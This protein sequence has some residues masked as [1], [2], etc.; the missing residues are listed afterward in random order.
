MAQSIIARLLGGFAYYALALWTYVFLF[1][2]SLRNGAFFTAP[3]EKDKNHL[4]IGTSENCEKESTDTDTARDQFWNLHKSPI[5]GFSH[6]FHV[7]R[8]GQQLHYICNQERKSQPGNLVILIHGFPDSCLMWKSLLSEPAIP[9]REATYVCVDLPGYGGSDSLGVH[10]TAVLEALTEFVVAMR[11]TFLTTDGNGSASK[12][13]YIVAHDWGGVLSF[14][15]AAEAPTLA[16]RFIIMN[17]PLVE[18]TLANGERIKQSSEK[19]FKQFRQSP[20]TN[21]GC[22]SKA[23]KTAAPLFTQ[24]LMSGYVA[25]FQLPASMVK[26]LGSGGN[27]AFTRGVNSMEHRGSNP[28]HFQSEPLAT[29]LGPSVNECEPS[30]NGVN[31]TTEMKYGSSVLERA[32]S[33]G[34][35]FYQQTSYYR[36]GAAFKPWA[37]TLETIADLY[38]LDS[39]ASE[40]SSPARRRSSSSASS[41][42]FQPQLKGVLHSPVTIPWGG[43]D[44]ALSKAMCLDGIGDYLA[45]DSEVVLLPRTGHWTSLEPEGRAAVAHVVGLYASGKENALAKASVTKY[46]SEVYSGAVQMVRK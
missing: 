29:V 45:K 9:L 5:P 21:L 32:K 7:L 30:T 22:L 25:S 6:H 43:K 42:L 15:L 17:A 46:V 16:D 18:L 24:I 38:A 4:A 11:D 10:D 27:M 28:R 35:A 20:W 33:P 14:R 36:D 40:S 37:K 23:I 41:A 2:L 3:T 34:E 13:T 19:I 26:Y 39:E 44:H 8:N 1:Y 12:N 31:G